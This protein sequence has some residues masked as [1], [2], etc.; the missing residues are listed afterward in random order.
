MVAEIDADPTV[1]Y[2]H[3]VAV[4]DEFKRL[5]IGQIRFAPKQR[6]TNR[7]RRAYRQPYGAEEPDFS[8]VVEEIEDDD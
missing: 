5:G 1:P 8:M 4:L 7:L 2:K 3:V 6:L